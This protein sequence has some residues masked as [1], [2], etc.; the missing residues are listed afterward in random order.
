M[1]D[2]FDTEEIRGEINEVLN[3]VENW[4]SANNFIFYGKGGKISTY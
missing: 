3:I 1:C 4:N 2:Y